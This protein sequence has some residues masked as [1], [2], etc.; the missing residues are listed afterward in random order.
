[1]RPVVSNHADEVMR[2]DLVTEPRRFLA[3]YNFHLGTLSTPITVQIY[4]HL[5]T[6]NVVFEQSHFLKVPKKGAYFT[7]AKH[8]EK[9]VENLRIAKNTFTK[10]YREAV[11][12][13][14]QPE[15]DWLV[16]N[17]DFI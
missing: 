8:G 13:G 9:Q 2:D 12:E 5:R 1:M 4:L 6:G 14:Y 3:E 17:E 11:N 10:F 15:E 16:R 7:D